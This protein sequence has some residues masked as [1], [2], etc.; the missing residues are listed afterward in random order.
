MASDQRD[1]R[2]NRDHGVARGRS[3]VRR[4]YNADRRLNR[5]SLQCLERDI[6]KTNIGS[7]ND[8]KGDVRAISNPIESLKIGPSVDAVQAGNNNIIQNEFE[9]GEVSSDDTED[10]VKYREDVVLAVHIPEEDMMWLERS[11]IVVINGDGNLS[12]AP[13]EHEYNW[14]A[15][16]QRKIAS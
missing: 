4:N 9:E 12:E 2:R 15:K 14:P 6:G 13:K 3:H 10:V 7:H 1:R 8:V 16:S 5:R 11:V